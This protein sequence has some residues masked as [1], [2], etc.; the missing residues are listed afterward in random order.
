MVSVPTELVGE[1]LNAVCFVMDYVEFHFNGPLL[2]ALSNPVL[3]KGKERHAFPAPGSR[4]ALCSLI[5]AT[6]VEVDV[7][8]EV[9]IE[10]GLSSGHVL[11]IPLD[12]SARIGPEAAHFLPGV[13]GPLQVW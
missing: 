2:R 11:R 9:A 1:E 3:E 5:G 7:R 12:Q 4:D 13:G 6:V 10:I 8:D